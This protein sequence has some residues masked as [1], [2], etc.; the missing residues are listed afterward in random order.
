MSERPTFEIC[1]ELDSGLLSLLNAPSAQGQLLSA[2][3]VRD[4]PLDATSSDPA[5]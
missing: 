3:T 1:F 4:V 2:R 5:E